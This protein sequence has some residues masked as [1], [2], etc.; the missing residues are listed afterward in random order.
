MILMGG[1]PDNRWAAASGQALL[2]HELTHVAQ[3]ASA[4]STARRLRRRMPFAEEHEAEAEL[5][6]Q[7]VLDEE[8]GRAPVYAQDTHHATQIGEARRRPTKSSQHAPEQ[9]KARVLEHDG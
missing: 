9:I 4:A 8:M 5:V 6:E 1:S 7:A 2:A 3:Q